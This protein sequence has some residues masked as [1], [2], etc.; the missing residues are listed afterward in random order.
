MLPAA[1]WVRACAWVCAFAWGGAGCHEKTIAD[2]E[3]GA[4]VAWLDA[5]GSPEAVAALGRLADANPAAVEKLTS[6]APTDE[7]AYIAAWT[8]TQRGAPWGPALLRSGLSDPTRADVTASIMGRADVHL[9]A[10]V[11]DLESALVR[12]AASSRNG[13]VAS[14]LASAGAP[15]AGAV[16]R[17]LDD[18]TTRGAM[19]RGIGSPD[20][21]EEARKVLMTAPVASRNDESCV[22][23]VLRIAVLNDAMLG[24]L[25]RAAEP[26]LLGAAGR[27]EEFPCPRLKAMWTT[28]LDTR[29]L[30][31]TSGLTVP[32]TSALDRCSRD[33][34]PLLAE[35]IGKSAATHPL[36]VSAIDPYGSGIADLKETC[37]TMRSIAYGRDNPIVRERAEQ[38]LTHGCRAA[39]ESLSQ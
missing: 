28:A 6:R 37:S 5:N 20:A 38:A 1:L 11:P 15:A 17:R 21:S 16:Q 27:S 34:D 26:G 3:K 9:P 29:S 33:L 32:L 36:I 22:Q 14:V 18:A 24:W 8:A 35:A 13:A 12:I 2:A 25:A 31:D 10:F 30:A 4:D 23:A 39:R 7:N 19:C